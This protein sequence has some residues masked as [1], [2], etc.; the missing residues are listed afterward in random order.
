MEPSVCVSASVTKQILSSL[1]TTSLYN[2]GKFLMGMMPH[3]TS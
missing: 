3:V 2:R 1:L